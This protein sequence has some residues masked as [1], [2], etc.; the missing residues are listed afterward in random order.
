MGLHRLKGFICN[1]VFIQKEL[2]ILMKSK[3][4]KL[5]QEMERKQKLYRVEY[6]TESN[7]DQKIPMSKNSDREVVSKQVR[8]NYNTEMEENP[9][10]KYENDGRG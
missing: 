2:R 7:N 5:R 10:Y 6:T 3:L 4:A 1:M 9:K 8:G